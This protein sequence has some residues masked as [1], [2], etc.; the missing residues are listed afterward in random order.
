MLSFSQPWLSLLGS[1]FCHQHFLPTALCKVNNDL[2]DALSN[3]LFFVLVWIAFGILELEMLFSFSFGD[4]SLLFCFLSHPSGHPFYSLRASVFLLS[5]FKSK[6]PITSLR[7]CT[8]PSPSFHCFTQTWP[9]KVINGPDLLAKLQ[10][11]LPFRHV[12]LNYSVVYSQI[13][14]NV[15]N[16]YL[17]FILVMFLL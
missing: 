17:L 15:L 11:D 16:T 6:F 2:V 10:T 8:I 14:V 13:K 1:D 5:I 7:A 9:C 4:S 3:E 12:F